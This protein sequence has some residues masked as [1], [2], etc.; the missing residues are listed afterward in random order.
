MNFH[1]LIAAAGLLVCCVSV[2]AAD[3][4]QQ[5]RT[6]EIHGV[7][8]RV[9]GVSDGPWVT[10]RP[11]V[12]L[13]LSLV[14][15]TAATPPLADDL[16]FF[17]EKE[18][19]RLGYRTATVVWNI[20]DDEAVLIAEEGAREFI[21]KVSITGTD[22]V[23]QEE[24]K[25]NLLRATRER[26][27]SLGNNVPLVET[28]INDGAG[29]VQRLL[30]SKGF[31]S[32]TVAPPAFSVSSGGRTDVMVTVHEGPRSVFGQ[33]AING[34]LPPKTET[35]AAEALALR[36]QPFN[37]VKVEELR[38]Q[39]DRHAQLAGHFGAKITSSF[40]A[41]PR[42]GEVPVVIAVTPGPVYH[43]SQLQVAEAF[44]RGAQRIINAG[45]RPAEGE[46]W[47][48][49]DLDLMQRRVL[50]TGVF[51]RVDV[52]PV[53]APDREA[54]LIL[55]ISGQEGPRRTLG[56]YGGYETLKGPIL[57][58]EW[59]VVNIWDTGNTLRL[60]AGYEAGFEGGIR[61]ID[62]AI[63]NSSYA[64]DTEL[65][66]KTVSLYDYTHN[67][68]KLRTALS[69]QF[70]RH[71]AANAYVSVSADS[72]SSS[73][74]TPDE[75]GPDA[76]NT[77]AV[78]GTFS[79]DYRDNPVLPHRGFLASFGMEAGMADI[80]YLRTDL[81]LSYYQPITKKFRLAA[82]FQASAIAAPDGVERLP[83]DARIFNGGASTVRSFAEKELGPLSASGTPLGGTL[84]HAANVELSYEVLDNLEIAVFADAGGLS[85]GDQIFAVPGDLRYAI[86]LGLRYALPVGPLRVDYG[87][88]PDAR[89][90]EASGA[91]HVTLGFAF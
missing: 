14:E 6:V 66:A 86:G 31:L 82:N 91:L 13:Q 83:I 69:R 62:P 34:T 27:G 77:M 12:E 38:A 88:N 55:R 30:Q 3:K 33:I 24:L 9:E 4:A 58:V 29:L 22:E 61:W 53:N 49:E 50:D 63:L 85:T 81:R 32:A 52:A 57:G 67:S 35:I 10:L 42:G 23:S 64:S 60:R 78:G 47:S 28:E 1:S 56:L 74:L 84:M 79:L 71:I 90:G 80:R 48:T 8:V 5:S 72:A 76:Y 2:S 41:R 54:A 68:L 51:T 16:A 15:D 17:L 25:D 19:R 44:S 11:V 20:V 89:N 18:F 46:V 75:L 65:S 26:L 40:H 37:E 45:F 43:V 70:T 87:L 36:G 7:K 73:V 59:R 39:I 21:G